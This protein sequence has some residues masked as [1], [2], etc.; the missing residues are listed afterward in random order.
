V[1][2]TAFVT[3][4]EELARSL[5]IGDRRCDFS[6]SNILELPINGS[7]HGRLFDD[8]VLL[9]HNQDV[10]AE[11]SH[12]AVVFLDHLCAAAHRAASEYSDNSVVF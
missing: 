2:E 10:A 8:F 11:F 5:E 4:H 6:S 12:L 3:R 1:I 7:S 9:N